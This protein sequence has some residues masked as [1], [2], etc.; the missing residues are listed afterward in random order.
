MGPQVASFAYQRKD[1]GRSFVM[2]GLDWNSNP[3]IEDNR[4]FL[5]NGIV[6]AARIEVPVGGVAPASVP[7]GMVIA[8][9]LAR[10]PP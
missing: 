1:G 9:A 7:E 6:W 8:S 10:G 2:G 4:R 3:L 5:L